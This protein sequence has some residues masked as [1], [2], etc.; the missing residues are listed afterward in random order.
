MASASVTNTFTSGTTA[1]ASEVNQNFSDILS[2]LNSTGV[3]VYQAGSI[4]TAAMA[5]DAVTRAKMADVVKPGIG[6]I[7]MSGA[8]SASSGW[9]RCDGSAVSRTTYATL[10]AEIGTTFGT[11]DGS[12]TFNLPDMRG[13]FPVGVGTHTDT[14]LGDDEGEST[15]SNRTPNAST[16]SQGSHTHT[17]SDTATTGGP[18]STV[19]AAVGSGATRAASTHTHSVTVSGTT[20]SGGAHTHTTANPYLAVHFDIYAGV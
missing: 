2:F 18:S 20:S 5:N 17:F 12:T 15:E 10:F 11:G 4:N 16:D 3:N 8:S 19:N 14:D 6:D 9:L 7:K 1:V 13:R